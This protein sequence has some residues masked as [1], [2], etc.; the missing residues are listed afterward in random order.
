[1][2]EVQSRTQN[3]TTRGRGGGRGGR[4]GFS[5]RNTTARRANGDKTAAMDS[6]AFDDDGDIVQ[7]RKQYGEKLGL[8]KEL[9]ADWSDADI[10]Y[11]LK[12]TDG[13]VELT[14]TRIAD[15]MSS[16]LFPLFQDLGFCFVLFYFYLFF[17]LCSWR[18]SSSVDSCPT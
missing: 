15:G 14:A 18:F 13:D 10:L 6:P 5:S 11:A 2:A 16:I 7:L 17:W 12:E 1:M 9:F 8:I 4:G 3:P